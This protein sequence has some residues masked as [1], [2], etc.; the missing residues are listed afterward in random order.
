MTTK[1]D[2]GQQLSAKILEG[3]K[4]AGADCIITACP[5][6]QLNLEGYQNQLCKVLDDDCKIPVLYFTQLLGVALGLDSGELALK[7][8]LTLVEKIL[9]EKVFNT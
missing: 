9:S 5:L 7:D 3:A 2:V 6:C 4:D 1:P 8:S